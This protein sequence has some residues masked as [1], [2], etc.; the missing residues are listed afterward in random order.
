MGHF[1]VGIMGKL[2]EGVQ[3]VQTRVGHGNEGQGEG[4]RSPQGGLAVTQLRKEVVV[5]NNDRR[6]MRRVWME[7]KIYGPKEQMQTCRHL[8]L[9]FKKRQFGK[10]EGCGGG[11][12][13]VWWTGSTPYVGNNNYYE[14]SAFILLLK[15]TT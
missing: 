6:S 5:L 4:H 7:D 11:G 15:T 3:D 8:H 1:G 13:N 10:R 9:V 12:S 14:G 2:A